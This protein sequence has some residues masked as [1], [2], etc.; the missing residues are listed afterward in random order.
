VETAQH[1]IVYYALQINVILAPQ[2]L[3]IVHNVWAQTAI[4]LIHVSVSTH[5]SMTLSTSVIR[6]ATV[7]R[8][9]PAHSALIALLFLQ[10]IVL[11]VWELTE[12]LLTAYVQRVMQIF[13]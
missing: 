2:A 6:L 13:M 11:R 12:L 8:H 7:A 3:T 4:L 5:H 9:A 1:T 10:A